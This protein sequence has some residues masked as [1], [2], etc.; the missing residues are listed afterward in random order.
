[1]HTQ[2]RTRATAPKVFVRGRRWAIVRRNSNEWPFF[3]NGYVATSA[4]PW[5]VTAVACTSVAWP[6]PGDAFTKPV[7][8]TLQP[9][10][11]RLISD[12]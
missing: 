10:E 6:L 12:S 1:M 3:C 8:L 9:G 2:F 7:T 5:T 11:S 4:M